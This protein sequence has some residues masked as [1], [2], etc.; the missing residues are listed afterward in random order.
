MAA[1]NQNLTLSGAVTLY[2]HTPT[3]TVNN[4][5]EIKGAI[6]ESGGIYGITKAG[7]GT[8][9]LS[10]ANTYTGDTTVNAGTLGS[11]RGQ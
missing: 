3:I 4:T 2:Y 7:P 6:G 5:T 8:L 9:I 11:Q 10:G 1:T